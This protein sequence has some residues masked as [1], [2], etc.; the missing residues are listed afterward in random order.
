M[1]FKEGK[2]SPKDL[3]KKGKKKKKDS[4]ATVRTGS[5]TKESLLEKYFQIIFVPHYLA[6]T[7]FALK[8]SK[9]QQ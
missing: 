9:V 7:S 4:K 8:P 1:L 3:K 2:P 6:H 5:I